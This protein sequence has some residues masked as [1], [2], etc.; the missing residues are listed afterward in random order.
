MLG[1]CSG[2]TGPRGGLVQRG[3]LPGKLP[4]A[5]AVRALI[6]SRLGLHSVRRERGGDGHEG[7]LQV[8]VVVAEAFQ[9]RESIR[10]RGHVRLLRGRGGIRLEHHGRDF[11]VASGGRGVGEFYFPMIDFPRIVPGDGKPKGVTLED[12]RRQYHWHLRGMAEQL[13]DAG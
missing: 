5:E 13:V 1:K 12:Y 11:H 4:V 9:G 7:L 6:H 8:R 3:D 2:Y 10:L